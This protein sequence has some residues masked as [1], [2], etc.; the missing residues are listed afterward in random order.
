MS[1]PE[2]QSRIGIGIPSVLMVLVVLAMAALCMLS[3]SN[4]SSTEIMTKRN[5]EVA[6]GYY[7]LSAQIQERLSLLDEQLALHSG[8]VSAISVEGVSFSQTEEQQLFT[9]VAVDD[10]CQA[11]VVEGVLTPN[12]PLRYRILSHRA[13]NS[14][15]QEETYLTLMGGD[16]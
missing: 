8:D 5:V 10:G 12:Q 13:E 15:G 11:I 6:T 1:R 14:Y 4:A 16:K 9:L 7:Q 2:S 3:Y